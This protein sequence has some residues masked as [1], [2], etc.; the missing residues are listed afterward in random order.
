MPSQKK[1]MV[2]LIIKKQ[3]FALS[4][5]K[6]WALTLVVGSKIKATFGSF[7]MGLAGHPVI[8]CTR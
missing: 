7:Y 6:V 3:F 2:S 5:D 1:L 4:M 8:K